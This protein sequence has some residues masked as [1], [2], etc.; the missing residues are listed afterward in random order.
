MIKHII[1]D[2]NQ[3]NAIKL[4]SFE[5]ADTMVIL[6]LFV[7]TFLARRGLE[8]RK[9]VIW[10][11]GDWWNNINLLFKIETVCDKSRNEDEVTQ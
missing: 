1:Y 4:D 5:L 3:K 6:N 8:K 7:A 9:I 2:N 10:N 11:L